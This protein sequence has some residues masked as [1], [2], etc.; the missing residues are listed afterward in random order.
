[1]FVQLLVQLLVLSFAKKVVDDV[2]RPERHDDRQQVGRMPRVEECPVA[3]ATS[4][5]TKSAETF[6]LGA[7]L[8]YKNK[9]VAHGRN[10]N[11][12]SRGSWSVHAEMDVV[13]KA[14]ARWKARARQL[15]LV[16]VRVQRD[17]TTGCSKPCTACARLLSRLGISR[18]TYT[19]GDPDNPLATLTRTV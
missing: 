11:I 5:A 17:G 4:E 3:L 10:R 13:R 2:R 15:H 8:L 19:T 14:P 18:V 7:V 12:N 6:R 16:V 1:M 9:V